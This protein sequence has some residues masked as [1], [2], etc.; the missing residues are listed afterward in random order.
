MYANIKN[1]DN[2]I[3]NISNKKEGWG[4]RMEQCIAATQ[5]TNETSEFRK[6]LERTTEMKISLVLFDD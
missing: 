2:N 4:N 6:R 3:S 5:V 1:N